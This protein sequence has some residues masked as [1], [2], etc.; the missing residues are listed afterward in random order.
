M[1]NRNQEHAV[2]FK[3]YEA[4]NRCRQGRH[5]ADTCPGVLMKK[6]NLTME[7]IIQKIPK[8][9]ISE[10]LKSALEC[11]VCLDTMIQRPIFICENVQGHSVC[12]TCHIQIYNKQDQLCPVCREKMGTRRSVVLE[13]IVESL[14]KIKC[15][16]DGC[17]FQG[18]EAGAVLRHAE[19]GEKRY[20]PCAHCDE[21][22]IFLKN[23]TEHLAKHNK[24]WVRPENFDLVVGIF[25][26][27]SPAW[28]K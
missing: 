19:D 21:K 26:V 1:C 20:I 22:K 23:F 4:D 18:L 3:C 25:R 14:P 7:R 15:V 11:P 5:K 16:H 24:V 6:R 13:N 28:S 8:D 9:T 2:C 27:N 12:S 17:A 10:D